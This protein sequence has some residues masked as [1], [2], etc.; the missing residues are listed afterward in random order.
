MRERRRYQQIIKNDTKINQK[1]DRKAMKTSIRFS[2]S[3]NQEK[4][5]HGAP[6][7]RK[8]IPDP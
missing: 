4:S 2:R 6:N 1:G 3:K 8:G 7:G 5:V